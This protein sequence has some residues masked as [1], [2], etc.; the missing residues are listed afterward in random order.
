MG[1][2]GPLW[3][4][5]MFLGIILLWNQW[6]NAAGARRWLWMAIRLAAAGMLAYLLW[7]YRAG[8]EKD[9]MIE[10]V[11]I[12]ARWWGIVGLIG[13]AYLVSALVWLV[14]RKHGA[15]VSGALGL[16]V[17]LHI[18]GKCGA[19]SW[20]PEGLK[21]SLQGLAGLAS[22]STAGLVI[23]T[24]FRRNSPAATPGSRIAWMLAFAAG[25]AVAGL[26]LRPL[27]GIH[28]DGSTP[29]WTLCS[30]AIACAAY[31]L[32]YWLVD[33]KKVTR[34]TVLVRP[35]G[36]NTL[37]MYMLPFAFYSLLD[38][39]GIDYLKTHFHEGLSG[40][41]RSAVLAFGFVAVTAVLTRCRV[42]LQL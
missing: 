4:I 31:T 6:P 27:W 15:A 37:L 42:R 25:F 17:A 32:L 16:L 10:I 34:W 9:G 5:L 11:R 13:W 30:V 3:R 21:P 33:V 41:V 23:A 38:A 40:I 7:I 36:S 29:S 22:M 20:W 12:Q 19:L 2:R 35:A 26:S 24:F 8:E 39:L 1:L 14:C 18:G 28:K